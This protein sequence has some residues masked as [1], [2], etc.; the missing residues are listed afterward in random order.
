MAKITDITK[1][2][3]EQGKITFILMQCKPETIVVKYNLT[4]I[5][6]TAWKSF[7]AWSSKGQRSI[8]SKQR[9]ISAML[10]PDASMH[11]SPNSAPSFYT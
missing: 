5:K 9:Y 10:W 11:L 7:D 2:P 3:A 4:S 1:L 6:L 8:A